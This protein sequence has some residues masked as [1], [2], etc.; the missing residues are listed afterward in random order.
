M[1]VVSDDFFGAPRVLELTAGGAPLTQWSLAVAGEHEHARSLFVA[2]AASGDIYAIDWANS[3]V[4]RYGIAGPPPATDTVPPVTK[5]SGVD[6]KWH[7]QPVTL[8]YTTDNS[9]GSGVAYTESHIQDWLS[10][11][12]S[13]WVHGSTY[14]IPA[15]AHHSDDGDRSVEFRSADA[16]G[17]VEKKH[18]VLV[19]MDTTAP[20]VTVSPATATGGKRAKVTFRV[21]EQLSPQIRVHLQVKNAAGDPLYQTTSGWLKR[22]PKNSWT[23]TCRLDPGAYDLLVAGEDLAGDPGAAGQAK[24]T[25]E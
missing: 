8:T 16:A 24:L 12:W 21:V 14:V 6:K 22:G 13:D 23:F 1:Y 10:P 15:A 3:T 7:N 9:G 25:V 18:K 2:V 19:L 4:K 20:R 17:N 5:V 11:L